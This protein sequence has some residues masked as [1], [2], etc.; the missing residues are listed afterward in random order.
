MTNKNLVF[1]YKHIL[2]HDDNHTI[3]NLSHKQLYFS[4]PATFP[5][6]DDFNIQGYETMTEEQIIERIALRR[7]C[8]PSEAKNILNDYVNNGA[9]KK[10]GNMYTCYRKVEKLPRV[11]CFSKTCDSNKMWV[12]HADNHQG[13]CLCFQCTTETMATDYNK[14]IF[15]Q[16]GVIC[17]LY[18]VIYV[19]SFDDPDAIDMS[20]NHR[21]TKASDRART[22]KIDYM[23]EEECRIIYSKQVLENNILNYFESDLKG[24]I[25][26]SKINREKAELVYE[27]IEKNYKTTVKF[28]KSIETSDKD[29]VKI[30]KIP[31]LGEYIQSLI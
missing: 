1:Q 7:R 28:Y 2:K 18:E 10:K 19:P 5:D 25:F 20:D 11:C 15:T 29:T 26:G 24:I 14:Q 9:V 16:Q 3:E 12:E 27:T 31:D 22:K 21:H 23:F 4:D 8:D 13:I 6:H 30:E 17:P